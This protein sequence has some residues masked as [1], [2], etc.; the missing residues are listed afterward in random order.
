MSRE[1][2]NDDKTIL[3][4]CWYDEDQ[5]NLL[6]KADP[7][8]VDESYSEWRKNAND[9]LSQL[10]ENGVNVQK[11]SI[12]VNELLKWCQE[13][14]VEPLGKARSEYAALI[15]Q[16]RYKKHSNTFK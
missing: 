14:G 16:K 10:K 5:W 2:Q 7:T 9:A 8:G 15:A 6:A 13:K 12:N 11:I 1:L 4:F 3:A